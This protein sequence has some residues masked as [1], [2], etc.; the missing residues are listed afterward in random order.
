M[1]VT[2]TNFDHIVLD[3]VGPLPQS[4]RGFCYMLVTMDYAMHYPEEVTLQD[5]QGTGVAQALI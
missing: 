2:E 1:P 4:A 3:F 5:M